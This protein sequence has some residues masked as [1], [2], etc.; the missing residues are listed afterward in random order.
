MFKID[1]SK[2]ISKVQI[3]ALYRDAGW[4]SYVNDLDGLMQAI[5]NSLYVIG[6][7]EGETLVGLLRAVGD[8]V[9]IVYIQDILVKQSHKRKGIGSMLMKEMLS[10]FKNVRQI[11]LLTDDSAETRG[12]YEAMGMQSCDHGEVVAFARFR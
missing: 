5:D 8:G 12:F 3:E 1:K 11:V 9:V 7:W 6:A 2:D 10:D 4:T